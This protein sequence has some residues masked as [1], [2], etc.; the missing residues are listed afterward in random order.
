MENFMC[1]PQYLPAK[2]ASMTKTN[3]WKDH[4]YSKMYT[5]KENYNRI[6][7]TQ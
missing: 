2:S 6:D 7:W 4:T 5:S 3:N 1:Y